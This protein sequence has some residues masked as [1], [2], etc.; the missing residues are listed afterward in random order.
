[1]TA[2]PSHC[3]VGCL[4]LSLFM[5]HSASVAFFIPASLSLFNC[6]LMEPFSDTCV[7]GCDVMCWL[8][9][10]VVGGM[11]VL[12]EM[13]SIETDKKDRPRTDIVILSSV[14]FTDPFEEVRCM[15]R[16]QS[17]RSCSVPRRT[18]AVLPVCLVAPLRFPSLAQ[19]RFL[20]LTGQFCT[21]IIHSPWFY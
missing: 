21:I 12:R 19:S 18:A 7:L 3:F 4:P 6:I 10:R 8:L 17:S 11:P 9:R 13:E 15:F 2:S 5:F 1:M 16:L 20:V 14:V